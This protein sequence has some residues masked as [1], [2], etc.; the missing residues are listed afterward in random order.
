MPCYHPITAYQSDKH[1][2]DNG[3]RKLVFKRQLVQGQAYDVVKV[4][5]GKCIGC[6]LETSRQWA[7]RCVHEASLFDDNCFITLT[8]DDEHINPQG[9]LVKSDFQKFMKR[10]RKDHVGL[11]PIEY[12]GK[13]RFPIRYF[14]CGEYGENLGRPHFHACLFNFDFGD[15]RLWNYRNGKPVYISDELSRLWPNG[16]HEI[17]DVTFR[18][19]AYVARYITKKITG[20]AAMVH[21]LHDFDEETGECSFREQ[22]F[23]TMSRRPGIGKMFYDKHSSDCYPKDFIT[24]DGTKQKLPK[25]YDRCLEHDDEQKLKD[26]KKIR[27]IARNIEDNTLA[28]LSVKERVKKSQVKLLKRSLENET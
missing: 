28:R 19:A 22:E 24:H 5:C 17:G 20:D 8:Y 16:Y 21:Y 1:L 13:Q 18:S 3:K 6:K 7:L 2:T 4:P 23:A 27:R 12:Q 15:K 10:L 9:T 11:Q 14:A 25:Y 26:V